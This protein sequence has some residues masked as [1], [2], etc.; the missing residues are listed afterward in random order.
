MTR[1]ARWPV[2]EC[3]HEHTRGPYVVQNFVGQVLRT[4]PEQCVDCGAKHTAEGWR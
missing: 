1:V 2:A 3:L 4:V